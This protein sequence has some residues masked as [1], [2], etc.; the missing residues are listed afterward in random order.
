MRKVV[1]ALAETALV[2]SGAAS[3]GRAG[4]TPG[5][6]ILGYH[7][8]VPDTYGSVGDA[9]LHLRFSDFRRQLDHLQH[10]FEIRS[11]GT[12]GSPL[13]SDRPVAFIT[14]DDAYRD[15]VELAGTELEKRELPATFFTVSQYVGGRGFWWDAL[16]EGGAL[17]EQSRTHA[18]EELA[19]GDEDVRRWASGSELNLCDN[20]DLVTASESDL[21]NLVSIDGMTLGTHT[22]THPNLSALSEEECFSEMSECHEWLSG[23]FGKAVIKWVAYPYGMANDRVFKA[24]RR[25]GFDGGVMGW[26]G[27]VPETQSEMMA[28]PRFN[29]PAGV[30]AKGFALRMAGVLG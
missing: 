4:R 11:L 27:F 1:K 29:V 19:G 13:P 28:I 5:Q 7:N 22:A 15:A 21:E 10:Y 17:D 23:R 6:V 26:G 24:A 2:A 8:V 14:F 20:P 18:L 25:A 16:G 12:F 9:S 3:R 30:T